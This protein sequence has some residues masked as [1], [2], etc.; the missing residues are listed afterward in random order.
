[1]PRN[2]P[3]DANSPIRISSP[4]G[5]DLLVESFSGEEQLGQ[6]FIFQVKLLSMNHELGFEK[7]VGQK[8][9]ITLQIAQDERYFDGYITEFA[10]AH[11]REGFARYEATIR[12]W[13]WGLTQTS[14]CR[15]F[16][17]MKVLDIIK[18][19][20]GD[21][22]MSDFEPRLTR[23]YRTWDYCVQYNESDFN[24]VSRLMEHEG[25]Y[26]FFEHQ[27]GKHMMVLVDDQNSHDPFPGHDTISYVVQATD[28]NAQ[29]GNLDYWSARQSVVPRN[30]AAQ[31]FNFTTPK[32]NLLTKA[33]ESNEN[34]QLVGD[35]EIY[36]Y[37]G[38]YPDK[39]DGT[40]Y[41]KIRMQELYCQHERLQ[42]GGTSC[43]IAAGCH[44][45]L[46]NHFRADQ[47]EKYLV[48]SV[49]HHMNNAAFITTSSEAP[50]LYRCE[51]EVINSETP[52]RPTRQTRKPIVQGPQTAIVVGPSGQEIYTDEYGRV[53]VQFH[54]DR[55]GQDDQNSSCWVRVSQLWAG[56]KW[57]AIHLPR[58]G[59]EVIVSF[60]EGDPDRPIITG[61]VYNA[62]S[63]P[64]YDL[65]D[66]KTQSGV[67]TRSSMEGNTDTYNELRFEDLKGEEEIFLQAE[68]D[69]TTF[70]ENNE[71]RTTVNT[72]VVLVGDAENKR[73]AEMIEEL[74]VEGQ[75]EIT[76]FGN[77]LLT[78]MEGEDGRAVDIKDGSYDLKVEKV[79]Y[80]L[81][82][83]TGNSK[84]TVET[85][86][87]TEATKGDIS[88]TAKEGDISTTA[89]A[90]DI[91]TTADAGDISNEAKA[92][93]ISTSAKGDISTTAK[94]GDISTTAKKGNVSTEAS[95]GDIS[96]KAALGKITVEAKTSIEL[97][98]GTNSIKIST[99]GV[100]IKGG[101][102]KIKGDSTA[103][104]ESALTTV[105]GSGVLT[106][107]GGVVKIN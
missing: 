8:V 45:T 54:W 39:S 59:Q 49:S 64:P 6:P 38:E 99:S 93:D 27:D 33:N 77:D 106:L 16:Q 17:E 46:E 55:L 95:K 73:P 4:V 85:D 52:F 9:T 62:A 94:K 79:D 102:V 74:K 47:N 96:V 75:R 80:I 10:S 36:D 61:R 103:K 69:L 44:F 86:I 71:K 91:S 13:F 26:Y 88:T 15:I 56:A 34:A 42:A 68:K 20:F 48:V 63:M 89:E 22:G 92:G 83:E 82:V 40:Q 29:A 107:K 24:F 78:V 90:G 35:S 105:S 57:G 41:A 7:V 43:G 66:N 23:S 72:R 51:A 101:R 104:L 53:K 12:P 19:V 14:D 3:S 18:Q 81:A 76:I 70:V 2:I 100:T 1:M 5:G 65:P 60:M 98:V 31:D 32:S 67:K 11:P 58:M 50:E 28:V 37:P 25:I 87:S 30:Y 84:T 21:N 97:K